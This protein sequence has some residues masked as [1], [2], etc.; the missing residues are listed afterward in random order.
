M[1]S[2]PVVFVWENFGP[3][4]M[5]RCEAA[6]K[7]FEGKRQVIGI[8]LGGR[9]PTYE[10][11]QSTSSRF[12]KIT[13]FPGESYQH[14]HKLQMLSALIRTCLAFKR[15]DLFFC[16]Y[17][18]IVIFVTSIIMR[19]L[20][21]RVIIM[22][23]SKFD[24]KKR[25][26]VREII[27]P[28][29][30]SPYSA[31]FVSSRRAGEYLKFLQFTRKR[32]A[33]GYDTV[34]VD[35]I[36]L[37]VCTPPAPAGTKFESRHF[38]VVAR[39]VPKKNLFVLLEAFAI[40]AESARS[41]RRLHLCGSGPQ[42]DAL[43]A[44]AVALA[45]DEL[46]VFRGFVSSSEVSRTLANSLALLLVSTEEQFGLAIAEA[47]AMGVPIIVSKNCGA[48]DELVR[49]GVNGFVVEPD[50]ALGIAYFMGLIE[51]DEALWRRLSEGALARAPSGDVA[52]FVRSVEELASVT[53]R[54]G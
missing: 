46:V 11:N 42:M 47:L 3:M 34:S 17:E 50:N 36:R 25:F 44:R 2:R 8:E 1:T 52:R 43:R 6:A 53:D 26:L 29:F 35:R 31:A 28:L 49:S 27:K 14:I 7:H 38:T 10:W 20:G 40:Y 24:D 18:N 5:D 32:I 13:L 41:P 51:A 39:M 4:H 21:R 48:R 45:I 33:F 22:N 16:H 19:I 12:Q 15:A 54:R 9:S 37:A 23:D 30:L